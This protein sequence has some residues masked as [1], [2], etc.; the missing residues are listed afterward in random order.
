MN[1][2]LAESILYMIQDRNNPDMKWFELKCKLTE[3]EQWDFMLVL[4]AYST[5]GARATY[6][7]NHLYTSAMIVDL[8]E[9]IR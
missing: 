2:H 3:Q 1:K 4:D 5:I 6:L 8:F 7:E 9:T